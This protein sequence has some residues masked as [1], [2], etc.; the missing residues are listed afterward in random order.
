L[1]V[2]PNTPFAWRENWGAF[3]CGWRVF[4]RLPRP[5]HFVVQGVT[6]LGAELLVQALTT[7]EAE[8]RRASTMRRGELLDHLVRSVLL[9]ADGATYKDV[10]Q[11]EAVGDTAGAE[12]ARHA[13]ESLAQLAYENRRL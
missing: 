1:I 11:R 5:H 8:L 3:G 6:L 7:S 12:E 4:T 2:D 13:L 9:D 10:L